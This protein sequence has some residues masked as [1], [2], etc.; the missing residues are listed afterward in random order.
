M[1]FSSLLFTFVLSAGVL[2]YPQ[3]ALGQQ[4][5][6]KVSG[7]INIGLESGLIEADICVSNWPETRRFALNTGMNI[8]H[9]RGNGEQVEFDGFYGGEIDGD[10]RIYDLG[11]VSGDRFCFDYVG[12]FPVYPEHDFFVDYKGKVAFDGRTFRAAEQAKIIPV[13][14]DYDKKQALDNLTYD[15]TI[16][17]EECTF[18]YLNGGIPVQKSHH[19]FKSDLPRQ[20]LLFAGKSEFGQLEGTYFLNIAP[21]PERAGAFAGLL[22]EIGAWYGK[23]LGVPFGDQP[24]FIAMDPVQTFP[25]GRSWGFVNWPTIAFAGTDPNAMGDQILSGTSDADW[26]YNFLGHEAGHYYFGATNFPYG[27]YGQFATESA[28]EFMAN[29]YLR[30]VRGT[31]AAEKRIQNWLKAVEGKWGETVRF[32]MID[33]ENPIA[34]DV[35]RYN[36]GPILLAGLAKRAGDA[37]TVAFLKELLDPRTPQSFAEISA[38]AEAAGISKTDWD[39]WRMDCVNG[40]PYQCLERPE[41]VLVPS[42]G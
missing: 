25:E 29:L 19:T 34:G 14:Y 39:L 36:V 1:R 40:T 31:E 23:K 9:V 13:P 16:E 3:G 10:A 28:A 41:P 2:F 11:E 22:E 5:A 18:I 42:D 15:L 30:E 17:C 35:Y 38:K 32:D 4:V 37:A 8:G 7:A 33:A 12:A 26:I 24:V 6:P 20:P 27:P 21:D